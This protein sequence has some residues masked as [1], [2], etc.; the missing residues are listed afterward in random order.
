MTQTAEWSSSPQDSGHLQ[1]TETASAQ[2]GHTSSLHSAPGSISDNDAGER[3]V[4]EKLK[5]TSIASI[6][7]HGVASARPDVE[8]PRDSEMGSQNPG[9]DLS[10][11]EEPTDARVEDRGRPVRKRSLDDLDSPEAGD[12]A[13]GDKTENK[14]SGHARK[15]SR[16]VRAGEALNLDGRRRGGSPEISVQEEDEGIHEAGHGDPND[17]QVKPVAA[18]NT[19]PTNHNDVDEE[20]KESALSPRKKRSRDQF[21]SE[22]H[23]EQKIAATDETKARRRSS[24]ESREREPRTEV[25]DSST[26]DVSLQNGHIVPPEEA[27][28]ES[29]SETLSK[30]HHLCKISHSDVYKSESC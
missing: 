2:R 6:P 20:M 21:E 7:K 10:M 27:S 23:R 4:R 11:K 17:E 14:S 16:D 26:K 28:S 13:T 30:V 3:P 18:P 22:T 29:K 8:A 9:T 12:G 25:A 5:K 15:R 19:P 1:P 24:E